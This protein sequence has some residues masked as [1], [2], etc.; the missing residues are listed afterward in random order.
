MVSIPSPK[1]APAK[2]ELSS[3]PKKKK[4]LPGP[5]KP[6]TAYNFYQLKER[7]N[8]SNEVWER[9]GLDCNRIKHNA[10]VARII[11]KQWRELSTKKREEFQRL[12]KEDKF[13]YQR[14]LVGHGKSVLES[15]SSSK[16]LRPAYP[17][18]HAKNSQKRQRAP[19]SSS[20]GASQITRPFCSSKI[21]IDPNLN[22][23]L[24]KVSTN[25]F[26]SSSYKHDAKSANF[27]V[28]P[29]VPTGATLTSRAKCARIPL[30]APS[31]SS[32]SL[33]LS[34]N[35]IISAKHG[36]T[37]RNPMLSPPS[38]PMS[39]SPL[40]F[41]GNHSN[42]LD[43]SSHQQSIPSDSRGW[44]WNQISSEVGSVSIGDSRFQGSGSRE[45]TKSSLPISCLSKSTPSQSPPTYPENDLKQS[46]SQ[47]PQPCAEQQLKEGKD[48]TD[49]FF[50]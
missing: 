37:G 26:S 10:E 24:S 17:T 18:N 48:T 3:Q 28:S 33:L 46:T 34:Q 35:N 32:H 43:S 8:V 1:K 29:A 19:S 42:L 12:A 25:P 13:R 31:S 22:S 7:D 21:I 16:Q 11:G 2:D 39:G 38:L 4:S 36:F 5:K 50:V 40:V 23:S 6:K 45:N 44:W 9:L 20:S 47:A 49:T 41:P 30:D 15:S 27:R 14:E